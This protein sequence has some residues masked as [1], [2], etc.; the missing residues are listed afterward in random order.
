MVVRPPGFRRPP[1]GSN[2]GGS[3]RAAGGRAAAAAR[4]RNNKRKSEDAKTKAEAT[5]A[6]QNEEIA[7]S[8]DV[9]ASLPKFEHD[10]YVPVSKRPKIDED[11]QG[12]RM[13]KLMDDNSWKL[14]RIEGVLVTELH[15]IDGVTSVKKKYTFKWKGSLERRQRADGH[16]AAQGGVRRPL[17]HVREETACVLRLARPRHARTRAHSLLRT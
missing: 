11:L 14:G 10:K 1:S 13:A 5:T 16:E 9:D 3:R 8:G 15:K 6:L 17:G 12:K 7:A 2:R 4:V